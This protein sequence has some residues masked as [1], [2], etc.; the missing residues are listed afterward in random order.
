MQL[1]SFVESHVLVNHLR[2]LMDTLA[3]FDATL[4]NGAINSHHLVLLRLINDINLFNFLDFF[5]EV[6]I[7][8][9]SQL[10]QLSAIW[11]L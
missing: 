8:L 1:E 9:G 4:A 10:C 5:S 6:L 2:Q 11:A 3:Q 7:A